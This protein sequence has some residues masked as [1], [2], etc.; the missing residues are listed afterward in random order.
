MDK[1]TNAEREKLLAAASQSAAI[2]PSS[3]IDLPIL[4]DYVFHTMAVRWPLTAEQIKRLCCE[5]QLE[6]EKHQ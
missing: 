4:P 5:L 6:M 1:L 2:I 3:R